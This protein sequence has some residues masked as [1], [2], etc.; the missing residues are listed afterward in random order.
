MLSCLFLVL[1]FWFEIIE[2]NYLCL[3][4]LADY[5]VSAD[6]TAAHKIIVGG[7]MCK[8]ILFAGICGDGCVK[9]ADTHAIGVKQ[10]IR[11]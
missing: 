10:N 1:H 4:L 11:I 3:F 6:F 8:K 5:C 9:D 2:C 7:G